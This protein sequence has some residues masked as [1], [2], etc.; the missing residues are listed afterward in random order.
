[1]TKLLTTIAFL[2]L[3]CNAFA[4]TRTLNN[5]VPSPGQ[6][7]SFSACQAASS[8]GD[9]ILVQGSPINYNTFSL[10]KRLTI[11]GP[12][13]NPTD[14]Q[15][16]VKAQVD[17][18]AFNIGSTGSKVYGLDVYAPYI[19][20]SQTNVDSV[21]IALCRITYQFYVQA[22]GA[23]A[24]IFD[25]NVFSYNGSNVDI[26]GNSFG[27]CIFRNNIFNGEIFYLGYSYIGYNYI[28]NN[29]FLGDNPWT[30]NYCNN[31]YVYNNIFYRQVPTAVN[32]S[33]VY[34][35]NV[36][37]GGVTTFPN[38]TNSVS[39]DPLFV[40][41]IGSGALFNYATDYHLQATSPFL[42]YGNDG[43]QVGIYGGTTGDYNQNGMPRNPYIN[44]FTLS[45]PTSVNSGDS[46]QI[47]IKAK[48]RN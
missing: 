32:G 13:H 28:I 16:P 24:W 2:V 3:S 30:F 18:I 5:N 9:T 23:N 20:T 4:T 31:G 33:L 22:G 6:F 12:G 15:N 21:T 7:T 39:V 38:G 37:F 42:T 40:T 26:G 25:G 45:G 1:M 14:K 44:T 29:I 36:G 8:N 11:I 19:P 27:D 10:S 46:L 48:V 35:N 17:Y 47:Y 43:T 34:S 41:P